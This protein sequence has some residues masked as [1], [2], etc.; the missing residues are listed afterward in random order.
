M[1]GSSTFSSRTGRLSCKP[2]EVFEFVTDI[3]NFRQFIPA[4]TISDLE[5]ERESCSFRVSALGSVSL[6]LA[7]KVPFSK[8]VWSG[9]AMNSNGFSLLLDISKGG[10]GLAEVQVLLDTEMNPVLKMM[11]AKPV[12]QF[13]ETLILEMEKYSDWKPTVA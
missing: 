9:M 7:E 5:I 4:G 3:R 2:E 10:D 8:V 6:A 12:A 1:G 11:A 13:L